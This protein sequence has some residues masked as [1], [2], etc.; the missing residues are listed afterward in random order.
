MHELVNGL[1]TSDIEILTI[2]SRSTEYQI[3]FIAAS[4]N[5]YSILSVWDNRYF[6]FL[7]LTTILLYFVWMERSL[8]VFLVYKFK[9]CS[10]E[11]HLKFYLLDVQCILQWENFNVDLIVFTFKCASVLCRHLTCCKLSW[12]G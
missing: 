1:T 3:F 7:L 8:H 4:H 6:S 2:L 11:Q 9:V 12:M 10:W 5:N